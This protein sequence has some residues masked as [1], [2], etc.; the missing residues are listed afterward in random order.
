MTKPKRIRERKPWETAR[1]GIK[2]GTTVTYE[3]RGAWGSK[4]LSGLSGVVLENRGA[5]VRKER[6]TVL[7]YGLYKV[8]FPGIGESRVVKSYYLSD[9]EFSPSDTEFLRA[10]SLPGR[11]PEGRS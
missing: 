10:S 5:V 7:E 1:G 9:R 8:Y 11:L 4:A 3:S 6:G 2:P